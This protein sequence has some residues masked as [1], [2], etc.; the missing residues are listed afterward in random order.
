[1]L[2]GDVV[3]RPQHSAVGGDAT[4]GEGLGEAEVGQIAVLAP[5]GVFD[6]D[7][8]RLDVAVDEPVLV[9]CVERRG[10]LACDGDSPRRRECT[11][12]PQQRSQ[13][14][15]VDVA[16]REEEHALGFA[17]RVDR[18][19]VRVLQARGQPRFPLQARAKVRV[20]HETGRQHLERHVA[21]EAIIVGAVH[22]AHAAAADQRLD[23]IAGQL[24]ADL[25][26][27]SRDAH[28]AI[29]VHFVAECTSGA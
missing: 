2:R 21:A 5:A 20:V 6:E 11:L 12:A 18:D 10:D 19:D 17:R 28:A 4:I 9:R 1:L 13:V 7:V 22:L 24:A 14:G 27:L 25:Q 23:A 26:G 29:F 15:A 16:H 3:E 8:R